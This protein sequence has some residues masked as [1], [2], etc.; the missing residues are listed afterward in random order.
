[1][2]LDDLLPTLRSSSLPQT[3]PPTVRVAGSTMI[4]SFVKRLLP[5]NTIAN[6]GSGTWSIYDAA[7]VPIE[8]FAVVMNKCRGLSFAGSQWP[9]RAA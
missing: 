5:I 8:T 6:K 4:P 1:M 3:D 9:A 2:I 7:Q